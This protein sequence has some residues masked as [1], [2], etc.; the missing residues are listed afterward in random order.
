MAWI[1]IDVVRKLPFALFVAATQNIL[2]I[3]KL[4]TCAHHLRLHMSTAIRTRPPM[5][6]N[7]MHLFDPVM[8]LC[9]Y[10]APTTQLSSACNWPVHHAACATRAMLAANKHL[11]LR[12]RLHLH[13]RKQHRAI[14]TLYTLLLVLHITRS[15]TPSSHTFVT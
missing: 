10:H 1:R 11:H 15:G 14:Y 12:L 8:Q 3:C 2:P 6:V 9:T 7:T 4:K 5:P 13:P